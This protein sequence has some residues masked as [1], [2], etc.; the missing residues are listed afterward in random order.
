MNPASADSPCEIPNPGDDAPAELSVLAKM[1]A[2]N[3]TGGNDQTEICENWGGTGKVIK[4]IGG[5]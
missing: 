2:P 3:V 1:F 4:A 5:A